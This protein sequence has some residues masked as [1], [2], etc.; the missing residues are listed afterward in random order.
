MYC[1]K[2]ETQNPDDADFCTKC[3]N[4]LK[5][6]SQPL[7]EKATVSSR[8]VLGTEKEVILHRILA[9]IIDYIVMGFLSVFILVASIGTGIAT[10]S[11]A[12]F[13]GGLFM[14]MILVM[15]TWVLYGIILETWKGQT[16]GKMVMGIIVVKENGEPCDFFAALLR[17]VF[18]IIDSLPTLYLIG[19]IVIALTEKKQRLGDRLAGT[20]VVKVKK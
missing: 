1:N 19:F 15:A 12:G 18:R 7:G 2:C 5:P 11:L 13:F 20:I 14:A 16:V 9:V 3:G 8:G 4:N 17:N 6:V 10:L